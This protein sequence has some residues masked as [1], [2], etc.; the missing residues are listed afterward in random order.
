MLQNNNSSRIFV[1]KPI[2][3]VKGEPR[4]TNYGSFVNSKLVSSITIHLFG[5]GEAGE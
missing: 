1:I 2:L 4:C 3:K 5:R